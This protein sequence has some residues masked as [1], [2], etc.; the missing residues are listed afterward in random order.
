M[1]SR[2]AWIHGVGMTT[3]LGLRAA[4]TA[5]AVRGGISRHRESSI[6]NRKG[7][8]MILASLED[9]SL[10]PLASELAT[11]HALTSRQLR[12]L[13]LATYALREAASALPPAE[14]PLLLLTGPEPHPKK[15][16]LP[17]L[18][19]GFLGALALQAGVSLDLARSEMTSNG[20]AGGVELL[21]R[22]MGLL[23]SRRATSV[24]VGGVDSHLDTGL[25][26]LLDEEGRV[27]ADEV[28]DG[29]VPGEG[30]GFLLLSLHRSLPGSTALAF[31][32]APG[33][34]VEQG[35]RYSAEPCL[36]NGLAD[37]IRAAVQGASGLQI[38]TVLASF[39]GESFGAKEWGV[40]FIRNREAFHA[41]LR[42][43]HPA[44]CFGD[45]GAACGPVLVGLAALGLKKGYLPGPCLA[46]CSSEGALRAASLVS[47]EPV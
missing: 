8:P 6:I 18:G 47:G 22:A 32:S 23:H 26:G 10:P 45:L 17:P 44:D 7:A 28:L 29:F 14:R 11:R 2:G 27:H 20:R 37:A 24:L 21:G 12:M 19:E 40:A 16:A 13:R 35:H 1:E 25:L 3:P 43:E 15:P 33:V 4:A 30:A 38:R 39:N 46:W 34:G 42:M 31:V 36:G 41:E 5:A 9:E